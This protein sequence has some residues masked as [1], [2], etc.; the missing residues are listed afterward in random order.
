MGNFNSYLALLSALES[1]PVRRLDW[2]KQIVDSM[3]DLS[4]IMD[5]SQSFKNYRTALAEAKPPCLPYMYV[6]YMLD[7]AGL[8]AELSKGAEVGFVLPQRSQLFYSGGSILAPVSN[9]K[10]GENLLSK[11]SRR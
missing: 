6:N 7:V 5:S 11:P 9:S 10:G 2:S 3:A 4:A 1:G 8:V